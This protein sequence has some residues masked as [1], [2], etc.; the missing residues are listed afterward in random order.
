[1]GPKKKLDKRK[2]KFLRDIFNQRL[3][4]EIFNEY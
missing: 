1:M 4:L 2:N 3:Q